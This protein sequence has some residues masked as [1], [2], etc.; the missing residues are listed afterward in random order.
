MADDIGTWK[1]IAADLANHLA[2]AHTQGIC[3]DC[4]TAVN[5]YRHL[6]D[7]TYTPYDTS[8][9]PYAGDPRNRQ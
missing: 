3:P 9:T 5:R 6:R 7:G 2:A 4:I 1:R 8:T